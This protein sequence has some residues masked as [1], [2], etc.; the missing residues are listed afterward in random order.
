MRKCCYS[1]QIHDEVHLQMGSS[2]HES[3]SSSQA[4]PIIAPHSIH[5][6]LCE[7]TYALQE[8]RRKEIE[9]WIQVSNLPDIIIYEK[10]DLTIIAFR[11]TVNAQDIKND[12]ELSLKGN[13]S[14]EKVPPS[15]EFVSNYMSKTQN[16]IQLTGHSLGGAV[17]RCVGSSLGLGVVTFNP[18]APPSN[19]P[20]IGPN[21]VNYHIV[22]DIISAWIQSIRIDK[23]YRPKATGISKYLIC[24]PYIR[25]ILFNVGIKPILNAHSLLSFTNQKKGTIVTSEFENDLW[26]SWFQK[27]PN[28]FKKSFLYF[29]KSNELPPIP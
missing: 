10:N 12:I 14:F 5:W 8:S 25:D 16:F 23:D 18:A 19:P 13:C 27:L 29:I 15:I 20:S 1:C 28:L 21:Q 22:Y 9:G 4:D 11:G 7:E 17:A 6:V 26:T 3:F 24:I 2:T